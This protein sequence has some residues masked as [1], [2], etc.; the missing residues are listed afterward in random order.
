VAGS[1]QSANL[2]ATSSGLATHRALGSDCFF[3]GSPSAS[4]SHPC[5]DGF[6]ARFVPPVGAAVAPFE[7]V[8]GASFL[9]GAISAGELITLFGQGIG[10]ATG[11]E[12]RL[13]AAGR[14]ATSLNGVRVLFDEVPGPLLYAGPNQINA[15]PPYTIAS[16]QDV[17]VAI[18]TNGIAGPVQ[19]IQV[20]RVTPGFGAVAPG[21]FS[22]TASGA[23]QAAAF[24]EDGTVNGPAHPAPAGSI[25]GLY[26][27]GLGATN[28]P[29]IDGQITD[30]SQLPRIAGTVDVLIGGRRADVLYAGAAP[31]SISG[32]TQI[33]VRIPQGVSGNAPV[34]VSGGNYV[35]SQSGVWITVQ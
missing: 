12:Y 27:T 2:P 11:S 8:N 6:V 4:E 23:G 18:E 35:A 5:E 31:N 29:S 26:A 9:P 1:T 14:V 30:P 15:V 7:V 28:P 3:Q 20:A 17:T 32:V 34:Y 25:V 21:V 33:N 22:V 13:D 19:V 16:R 24:N 10:P